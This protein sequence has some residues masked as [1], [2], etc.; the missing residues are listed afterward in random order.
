MER[1]KH[2]LIIFLIKN[3]IGALN[4]DII[5]KIF[6]NNLNRMGTLDLLDYSY[7]VRLP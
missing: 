1:Y 5:V 2:S 6:Y 4:H 7:L 3:L